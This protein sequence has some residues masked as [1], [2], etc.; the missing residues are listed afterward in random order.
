MCNFQNTDQT[1]TNYI[2][3]ESCFMLWTQMKMVK[4]F[5]WQQSTLNYQTL[6]IYWITL[7]G[8][9]RGPMGYILDTTMRCFRAIRV[10]LPNKVKFAKL[11]PNLEKYLHHLMEHFLIIMMRVQYKGL[12]SSQSCYLEGTHLIF[13]TLKYTYHIILMALKQTNKTNLPQNRHKLEKLYLNRTKIWKKCYL[14]WTK[15]WTDGT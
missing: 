12:Y 1:F 9:T 8:T 7:K 10:Q 11:K 4:L 3:N 5:P 13:Y 2:L 6:K 15:I 14:H